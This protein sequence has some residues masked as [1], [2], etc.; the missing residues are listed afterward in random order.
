MLLIQAASGAVA[1][2]RPMVMSKQSVR[3]CAHHGQ[4]VASRTQ[5]SSKAHR[6]SIL[7]IGFCPP[8]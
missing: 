2:R 7:V 6:E 3:H 4:A 5:V 8:S 1:L